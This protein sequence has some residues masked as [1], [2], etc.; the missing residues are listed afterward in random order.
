MDQS[1]PASNND[2]AQ[3]DPFAGLADA[4][5]QTASD[6]WHGLVVGAA[7]L[8][9]QQAD[10]F[11]SDV[12]DQVQQHIKAREA[13]LGQPLSVSDKFGI[14]S[15]V[16]ENIL[17]KGGNIIQSDDALNS[18]VANESAK[19]N[20]FLQNFGSS[21]LN[22]AADSGVGLIRAFGT[23]NA[24][25]QAQQNIHAQY[26]QAEP[27]SVGDV[28][29]QVVGGVAS[30]VPVVASG[31]AA[32]FIMAAQGL[33]NAETE[34][35]QSHQQGKPISDGDALAYELTSAGLQGALGYAT[36][37]ASKIGSDALL[38][39]AG[40]L[41][42]ELL[43]TIT[44]SDG[45]VL[46]P[47]VANIMARAGVG[48]SEAEVL[49]SAQNIAA[50]L[51][52][53]DADRKLTQGGLSAGLQ[54]AALA[55]GHAAAEGPTRG[56]D[57][58]E[59]KE[60]QV[61]DESARPESKLPEEDTGSHQTIAQDQNVGGT[62]ARGEVAPVETTA[63]PSLNAEAP[64]PAPLE[65][66]ASEENPYEHVPDEPS[67][68]EDL[69]DDGKGLPRDDYVVDT[70]LTA[71]LQ[72]QKEDE[73]PS[74]GG[75][76]VQPNDAFDH[77]LIQKLH[78]MD[79]DARAADFPPEMADDVADFEKA[80]GK[81]VVG[82][83]S[84][85]NMGF[86]H[87]EVTGVVG[88]NVN[89][90]V[91]SFSNAAA[92]EWGHAFQDENPDAAKRIYDAV[93]PEV[94]QQLLKSYQD[95]FQGQYGP[96]KAAAYM[97]RFGKDEVVSSVIGEGNATNQRVRDAIAQ[98]DPGLW[99][100]IKE[101]VQN[102]LGKFTAKGRLINEM[103]KSI[104][105][106][107]GGSD[108]GSSGGA[109]ATPQ[110]PEAPDFSKEEGPFNARQDARTAQESPAVNSGDGAAKPRARQYTEM[111]HQ[112]EGKAD[113]E[114][115]WKDED[116]EIQQRKATGRSAT[117]ITN[118]EGAD[119]AEVRGRIDHTN[120]E[121]S[122]AGSDADYLSDRRTIATAERLQ[123]K[124]P[125]Y[126]V[127]VAGRG[128]MIPLEEYKSGGRFMLSKLD[129]IVHDEDDTKGFVSKLN[130]FT[131]ANGTKFE[132]TAEDKMKQ[133]LFDKETPLI[134]MIR[135]AMGRVNDP[136]KLSPEA[137]VRSHAGFGETRAQQVEKGLRSVDG[138]SIL[139]PKSKEKLTRD[140]LLK[141]VSDSVK[142]GHAEAGEMLSYTRSI[143]VAERTLEKAQQATGDDSITGIGK[144]RPGGSTKQNDVDEANDFLAK[145]KTEAGWDNAQEAI[146]RMRLWGN[147]HI[148]MAEESGLISKI[149]ARDIIGQN[150]FYANT[151]RVFE[152]H[153][154]IDSNDPGYASGNLHKFRGDDRLINDPISNMMQATES[155]AKRAQENFTKQKIVELAQQFPDLVQDAPEAAKDTIAV[156][157]AGVDKNF[158]VD[159]QVAQ[160][161]NGWAD[162]APAQKLWGVLSL[163]GR[164]KLAGTL[165][166]PMFQW[167][168][169]RKQ[170]QN[171]LMLGEGAGGFKG[172]ADTIKGFDP[173]A[174]ELLDTLGG[175][176][177]HNRDYGTSTN[178]Y[179][180]MVG[181][182]LDKLSSDPNNLLALPG[183]VWKGYGKL[184]EW[185]DGFN[186]IVEYKGA[187]DQAK[188]RGMTPL[189]AQTYAAW[190]ARDLMD[191]SVS[192]EIVKQLNN[193]M[194][195]PFMNA[196]VQGLRK[197]Y[198][199]ARTDPLK[200]ASRVAMFGLI[201][202][203]APYLYA[204]SQGK[205]VEDAYKQTPLAQRIMYYQYKVGNYNLMIPKGQTQAMASAMWEAF[206]DKHNG[207]IGTWAKAMA[208]SGLIPR[209]VVDPESM[210]PFQGMRDAVSNYSWFY[211]KNI[212]PPDQNDI[213]LDIRHTDG[214]SRLGQFIS[215]AAQK[216]GWE[217][218]PRKIDHVLQNDTGSVGIDAQS[219]S[220]VE[221]SDHPLGSSLPLSDDRMPAG[222]TSNS[223]QDAMKKAAYYGDTTSPQ[224]TAIQT[225]LHDSY[226]AKTPEARNELVKT[227]QTAADSATQFY[228][229]HGDEMLKA[230]E[231]TQKIDEAERSMKALP[232][233]SAQRQ[234][235]VENPDQKLLVASAQ[236]VG[237]IQQRISE[238][239]KALVNP[240]ASDDLKTTANKML[241]RL[242]GALADLG[243]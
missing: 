144:K 167:N 218:D 127:Y 38:K 35:D 60:I 194:Y 189:D 119:E 84:D 233:I 206:L 64:E 8:K 96:E 203:M 10:Q 117:H 154:L 28:A 50:R 165:I 6:P 40:K 120:K 123:S 73:T 56:P 221:R 31:V 78:A 191:F 241:T 45:R 12:T 201:P 63:G 13:Q 186:R 69:D 46:V 115:W 94:R 55:G 57:I 116:G 37:G 77:P 226:A 24:A 14:E 29:G 156:K 183:K 19:T 243:K 52:G 98:K 225:P 22:T 103:V 236:R 33:G 202:A 192:G 58:P 26:G 174:K 171:R 61:G 91:E 2:P 54:G 76:G 36:A 121:V 242:Y 232:T 214:A 169:F 193:I 176:M 108:E 139:D 235:L 219:V 99:S 182:T 131:P 118:G 65:R 151:S 70:D 196:E 16:R 170:T 158:T 152:D 190:R 160:V 34:V 177:S 179:F 185:A 234:Y 138:Q 82:F 79:P 238:L 109:E 209:Q 145:A 18:Q 112:A 124:F 173:A 111:G 223:V 137:Y 89:N 222:Y 141:P 42:P 47:Y 197:V 229:D 114:I 240:T 62:P 227:A 17:G 5:Q 211:G 184:G 187:L 149:Q 163:P 143:M 166:R 15:A 125:D 105:N 51:Y 199:M 90:P 217:M 66:F 102:F 208:D 85:K 104:R 155:L 83:T 239:R 159:P 53:I 48:A 181:K 136:S 3:N 231:A 213:A 146:R 172:I 97:K 212:V 7:G 157:Y 216:A 74:L 130:Q 25:Q 101:S 228:Q 59:G 161:V 230:K 27:G 107:I 147:E 237:V 175:T 150:K 11:Q 207:D 162:H 21:A 32:P 93:P 95:R 129:N 39:V 164:L 68:P 140:W 142:A 43:Q 67:G 9:Q 224:Y 44:A 41:S 86:Q 49:N 188:Q 75:N 180:R 92:H 71:R 135:T 126:E 110:I 87:P 205:D 220:N 106:R 30:A 198:E 134:K 113:T 80:T 88:V 210:L 23:T 128:G 132:I 200:A 153:A 100:S 178:D 20:T 81:K 122:V 148:R 195:Q 1:S 4:A 72:A 215:Q 168:H 204:K 133:Q